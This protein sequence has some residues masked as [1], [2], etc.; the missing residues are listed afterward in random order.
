MVM[1]SLNIMIFQMLRLPADLLPWVR[2]ALADGGHLRVGGAGGG[3]GRQPDLRLRVASLPHRLGQ[4]RAGEEHPL[5]ALR[6]RLQGGRRSRNHQGKP[7]G[8][9]RDQLIQLTG[10]ILEHLTP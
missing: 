7:Q 10:F 8:E 5:Q 1:Q 3:P 9:D 2:D 6:A 4:D